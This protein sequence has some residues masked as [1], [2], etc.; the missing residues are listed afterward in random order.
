MGVW[1]VTGDEKR[2]AARTEKRSR[3]NTKMAEVLTEFFSGGHGHLD[4]NGT[5]ELIVV[6][7]SGNV[8][9]SLQEPFED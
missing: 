9:S 6:T 5:L 1:V 4:G 7:V 3:R 8:M 2:R